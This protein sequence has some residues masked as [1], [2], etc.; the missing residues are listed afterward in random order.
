M[1]AIEIENLK[2]SEH[3]IRC[4]RMPHLEMTVESLERQ[5]KKA[6][7]EYIRKETEYQEALGTLKTLIQNQQRE[8]VCVSWT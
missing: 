5:L 6:T 1:H 2:D 4:V 3:A 7:E 8:R